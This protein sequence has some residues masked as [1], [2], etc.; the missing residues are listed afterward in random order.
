MYFYVRNILWG[1][2]T[3]AVLE[4][5][6]GHFLSNFNIWPIKIHFGWPILLYI[7][8]GMAINNLQNVLFQKMAEQFLTLISTTASVQIIV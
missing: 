1:P 5:T 8:N 2:L 7:F 4:I 3:S 6:V